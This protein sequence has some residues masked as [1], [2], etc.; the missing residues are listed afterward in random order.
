MFSLRHEF[1]SDWHAFLHPPDSA[2]DQTMTIN[3]TQERFP[4]QYRGKKIQIYQVDVFLK[5]RDIYDPVKIHRERNASGDYAAKP[6]TL[7]LTPPSGTAK[8]LQLVNNAAVLAGVPAGSVPQPPPAVPPVPPALG[9][10]GS[11]TLVAKGADIGAI[12]A[13]LQTQVTSGTTT[14]NRIAVGAIEDVFLV[15][16]VFTS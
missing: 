8:Q 14:N 7:N 4:F 16:R 2:P 12:A 13:S 6:L 10:L 1:P 5:F 9:P 15:C 11:W 3:L